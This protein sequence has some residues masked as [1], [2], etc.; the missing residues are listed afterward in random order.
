MTEDEIRIGMAMRCVTFVPGTSVKRF[1]LAMA[2]KAEHRPE[3]P[4]SEKQSLYLKH[5][6]W[7]YR[8]QLPECIV[9]LGLKPEP[10][11]KRS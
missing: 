5:L 10:K 1:A 7:R 9:K 6:A 2:W 3:S 4:L 11:G 8:A